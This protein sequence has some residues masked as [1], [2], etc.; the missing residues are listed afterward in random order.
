MEEL[1]QEFFTPV[2]S[3]RLWLWALRQ[4]RTFRPDR[5][6]SAEEETLPVLHPFHVWNPTS[7]EDFLVFL[8][9]YDPRQA[10]VGTLYV[11]AS[12]RPSDILGKLRALAD[13]HEYEEIEL[14]EIG[15][16]DVICYQKR[17]TS[18]D[19]YPHVHL[20]FQHVLD[21]KIMN[22]PQVAS[23]GF[24]YK[25]EAIRRWLDEG[26]NRS[27]MMNLA[28]PNQDLVP[29]RALRSLIQEYH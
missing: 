6:L 7:K 3:Q 9:L 28:L 15:N 17:P 25:A 26:N 5:P 18:E 19:K 13:I 11:K 1:T 23:N 4:N 12:S 21:Q 27:P 8:K 10:Y 2:Q 16:G 29:N 14:Y 20:F 24:T 22:D